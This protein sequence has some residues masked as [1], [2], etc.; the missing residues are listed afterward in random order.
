[1]YNR[2]IIMDKIYK[3]KDVPKGQKLRFFFDY[4]F[5]PI[6]GIIAAIVLVVVMT[7]FFFF[8]P[9]A[10]YGVIL[11]NTDSEEYLLNQ[12]HSEISKRLDEVIGDVNGDEKSRYTVSYSN[13]NEDTS[14]TD[15]EYYSAQLDKYYAEITNGKSL[16]LI[17]DEEV[18]DK[19]F[20]GEGLCATNEELGLGALS[21]DEKYVKIPLKDIQSMKDLRFAD[22]LYISIR[23]KEDIDFDNNSR[24]ENYENN[25]KAFKKILNIE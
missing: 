20:I 4:N 25:L 10:D 12:F 16:I 22:R 2:V 7:K 15:P 17:G 8:A 24:R 13:I 6:V 5:L 21:V 11:V 9:K 18:F 1:M 19:S 14:M 23:A 3:I